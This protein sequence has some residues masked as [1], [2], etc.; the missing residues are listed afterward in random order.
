[1]VARLKGLAH[2]RMTARMIEYNWQPENI[3]QYK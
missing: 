2:A 1:V 3:T